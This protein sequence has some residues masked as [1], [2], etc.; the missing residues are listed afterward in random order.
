MIKVLISLTFLFLISCSKDFKEIEDSSYE[1]INGIK[2]NK[3]IG[4]PQ[5][6]LVPTKW[7]GYPWGKDTMFGLLHFR[8]PPSGPSDMIGWELARTRDESFLII[9]YDEKKIKKVPIENDKWIDVIYEYWV[10]LLYQTR[11]PKFRTDGK[12]ILYFDGITPPQFACN[13][14]GFGTPSIQLLRG[15]SPIQGGNSNPARMVR[16]ALVVFIHAVNNSINSAEFKIEL[17][18]VFAGEE[19][20]YLYHRLSDARHKIKSSNKSLGVNSDTLRSSE[21]TS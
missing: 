19:D 13:T 8:Y 2:F 16:S 10:N 20:E 6:H 3:Q 21:S 7:D 11:Y 5:D 17:K 14:P 1:Y 12:T 15:E 9:Y 4:F 18:N